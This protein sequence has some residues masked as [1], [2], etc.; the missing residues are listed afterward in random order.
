MSAETQRLGSMW[1]H[2][3]RR[4]LRILRNGTTVRIYSSK[5]DHTDARFVAVHTIT[6]RYIAICTGLHV[7]PSIPSIPG[8]EHL[9]KLEPPVQVFHSHTYKAR[10]Q[11]SGK[12]VMIL[13]TGETGIHVSSAFT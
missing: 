2:T 10:S 7:I 12:R 4:A 9:S 3:L 13:G 1:S 8:I 5:S 6:A 11:L